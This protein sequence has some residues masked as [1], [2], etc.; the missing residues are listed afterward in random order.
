MFQTGI[1]YNRIDSDIKPGQTFTAYGLFLEIFLRLASLQ[2]FRI[3][4]I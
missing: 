3:K 4:N 2:A 1:F